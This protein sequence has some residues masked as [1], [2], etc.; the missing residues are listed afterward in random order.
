MQHRIYPRTNFLIV[1]HYR[2]K[3]RLRVELLK[4]AL[5]TIVKKTQNFSLG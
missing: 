2:F 5:S 3:V 1:K 4:T